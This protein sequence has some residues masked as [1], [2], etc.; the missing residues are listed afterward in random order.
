VRHRHLFW[1]TTGTNHT[2]ISGGGGGPGDCASDGKFSSG[3]QSPGG[4]FSVTFTTPGS[5]AYHCA[6][7]C[8]QFEGGVIVVQP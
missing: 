2:V 8:V 6:A 3:V 1:A 4:D 7:H 5:Y